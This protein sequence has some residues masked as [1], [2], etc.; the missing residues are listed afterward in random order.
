MGL[1]IFYSGKLRNVQQIPSLTMELL[2]LCDH[3]TWRCDEYYPTTRNPIQGI[4]FAPPGTD[5]IWMTFLPS[6]V[7]AEPEHNLSKEGIDVWM[8]SSWK[9]NLMNPRTQYAGPEAHMQMIGILRHVRQKYFEKFHLG[10]ESEFWETGNTE[11]CKDWFVMFEAWMRNM[12]SD[13]G[14]LDG[15]GYESGETFSSRVEDL[16]R[17]GK[18]VSDILKVMG[19]P[20]RKE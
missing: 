2:D 17:S 12:S 11:K 9:D 4:W 6:G 3:L 5:R 16:L 18:S 20:Y 10:D 14:K 1:S 13:L 15:R 7:L 8:K 19:S